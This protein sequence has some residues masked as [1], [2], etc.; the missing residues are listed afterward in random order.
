MLIKYMP[1]AW[2]LEASNNSYIYLQYILE[3]AIYLEPLHAVMPHEG[4]CANCPHSWGPVFS[5]PSPIGLEMGLLSCSLSAFLSFLW[6]HSGFV[7]ARMH[8]VPLAGGGS[9]QRAL[10]GEGMKVHPAERVKSYVLSFSLSTVN[11]KGPRSWWCSYHTVQG[12]LPEYLRCCV[13]QMA[14][15][16]P[17]EQRVWIK[18]KTLLCSAPELVER[19]VTAAPPGPLPAASAPRACCLETL[20]EDWLA[21]HVQRIHLCKVPQLT[22]I[23][24][25]PLRL[26]SQGHPWQG[27]KWLDAPF[28]HGPT[29]RFAG[30][31][32]QEWPLNIP[33]GDYHSVWL[34]KLEEGSVPFT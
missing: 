6:A 31:A 19:L 14:L 34:R 15:A 32:C 22:R 30:T 16:I 12:P 28:P 25:Q 7:S 4:P 29:Q 8:P 26:P 17:I 33:Y 9:W 20:V 13:E 2:N 3:P 11:M 23:P 27:E 10:A 1:S 24:L 18:N 21:S 5:F